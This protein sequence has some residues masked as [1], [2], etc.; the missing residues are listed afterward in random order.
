MD[1]DYL[2]N[3]LKD[4]FSD[5]LKEQ[6]FDLL[7]L[8]YRYEGKNLVL[9]ILVDKPEG[10]ISMDE[11]ANINNQISRLLYEKDLLQERYTLEV[12]SPGLD[13]P[14]VTKKDFLRCLNKAVKIFLSETI[15]GK[16]EMQG[17]ITR[18]DD[19]AVCIDAQGRTQV[20]P[21]VKLRKAKQIF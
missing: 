1:R 5:Y 17:V 14:L 20:I 12:S 4:L 13:R 6:N 8:I 11:C 2:T 15:E 19:D 7:E 9:R 18:V 10:G 16:W 3:V 21:L